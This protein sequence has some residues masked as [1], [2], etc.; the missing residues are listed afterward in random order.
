MFES[1]QPAPADPILGL[2][3]AFRADPRPDK[4]NLGVGVYQDAQGLTPV[5]DCVKAAE[6]AILAQETTKSYLPISGDPGYGRQVESLLFPDAPEAAERC[7]TAHS[8]G[9]TGALR[10][11]A[12]VLRDLGASST[13]WVSA[14]TW[15]NHKGVFAAAGFTLR[16]YPYYQPESRGIGV[17]ALLAAL[18]QIP[19]GDV[20]IL[21]AACHNPSGADPDPELWAAMA[22][23]AARRGWIPFLDN[24]YLGFG[25]GLDNDRTALRVFLRTGIE[26]LVATSFSKNL[27]LYRERVGALSVIVRDRSARDPVFSRVKK[28]IRVL[29]S[30]PPSHGG[31]VARRV[32]SDAILRDLWLRELT[33]MRERIQAMRTALVEGMARRNAR[34]DYSFV[35]RQS[36]MFSFTGLTAAQTAWLKKEK[37]LYMTSD[38]RINVA[39]LTADNLDRVCDALFGCPD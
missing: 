5:L 2:T 32:L 31:E 6:A 4:V 3:E 21:H 11:G 18:D 12:D 29:Y 20:V 37:G 25:Q 10:V 34:T 27:G 17:D 38:G 7:C 14:P 28:I 1:V 22:Q 23:T 13:A 15:A 24:A 16:E 36:G 9:G 35:T 30:N 19:A 26:F 33:T 8:P 39:G